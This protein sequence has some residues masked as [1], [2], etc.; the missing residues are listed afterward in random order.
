MG[1]LKAA[2]ETQWGNKKDMNM[3]HPETAQKDVSAG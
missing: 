2:A 3:K 1:M